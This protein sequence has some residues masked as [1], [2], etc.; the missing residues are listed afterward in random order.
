MDTRFADIHSV[1]WDFDKTLYK[2]KPTLEEKIRE[3]EYQV[4]KNHTGWTQEQTETEFAKLYPKE[5]Q[6]AT[7]VVALLASISVPLAAYEME[8][9]YDRRPYL[10]RDENLI[11][12][13]K[14]LNR[15]EHYLLVN[16][17]R[18]HVEQ[19]LEVL[20]VRSDIFRDIVTAELVGVNK[21]HEAGFQYIMQKTKFAPEEHLMI[22][23]RIHVDLEPAK[24]LG[25]KTCWIYWN[26]SLEHVDD[27]AADICVS[28]VYDVLSILT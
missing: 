27:S 19:A 13:F 14:K 28:R 1:I 17:Y 3:V 2:P 4:I 7:E 26:T 18:P 20:G 9:L 16:G 24:K 10:T 8:M 11:E 25:M 22:G 12:L 23:D 6:S 5:Y 15:Y 21:P